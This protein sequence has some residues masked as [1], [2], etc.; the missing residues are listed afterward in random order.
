MFGLVVLGVLI[1]LI[2]KFIK[3]IV[4]MPV[5]V[6]NT[7][8]LNSNKVK[9]GFKGFNVDIEDESA[10]PSNYKSVSGDVNKHVK[11]ETKNFKKK[12]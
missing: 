3:E 6:L 10:K 7:K 11:N 2:Y 4:Y 12:K 8:L 1:F 9:G 5:K